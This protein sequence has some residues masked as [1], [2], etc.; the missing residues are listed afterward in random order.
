MC[1]HSL[2]ISLLTLESKSAGIQNPAGGPF[3]S[4]RHQEKSLMRIQAQLQSSISDLNQQPHTQRA[5]P[6]SAQDKSISRQPPFS[7]L[8]SHYYEND[9]TST[10]LL[11]LWS[12]QSLQSPLCKTPSHEK[13]SFPAS[14][15]QASRRTQNHRLFGW[16]I[17]QRHERREPPP[18]KQ[19]ERFRCL[20]T[21]EEFAHTESSL[22]LSANCILPDLLVGK[23]LGQI[24]EPT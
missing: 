21:S 10:E 7:I 1:A 12:V 15:R 4:L 22:S 20:N 13:M 18:V 14:D 2:E 23:A 11:T 16:D 5:T 9:A 6:T 19:L 3:L 17:V 24:A 8:I